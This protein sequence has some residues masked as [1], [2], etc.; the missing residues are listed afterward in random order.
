MDINRTKGKT[1]IISIDAKK[2]MTTP[3]HG[4]NTQQ[5]G[6][7]RKRPQLNKSH[8]FKKTCN[9]NH[10]Q[11]WKTGS[12]YSKIKNKTR[13]PTFLTFTEHSTEILARANQARK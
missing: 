8:V 5:T 1:M 12:I 10:T 7:R 3:F 6:N 9:E 4:K 11:W 2:H 13:L